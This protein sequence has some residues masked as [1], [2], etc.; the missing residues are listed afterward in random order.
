MQSSYPISLT[1]TIAFL[2]ILCKPRKYFRRYHVLPNGRI[3]YRSILLTLNDRFFEF[4]YTRIFLT[5]A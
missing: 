1:E 4:F 2:Y 5:A 3:Y